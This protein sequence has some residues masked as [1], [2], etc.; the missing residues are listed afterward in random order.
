MDVGHANYLI[1]YRRSVRNE[2]VMKISGPVLGL[3]CCYYGWL[4]WSDPN[5]Q[6]IMDNGF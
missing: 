3:F 4:P 6:A 2:R 1:I 5:R